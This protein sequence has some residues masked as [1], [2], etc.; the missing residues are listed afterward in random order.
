MQQDLFDLTIDTMCSCSVVVL[1]ASSTP[2][3]AAFFLLKIVSKFRDPALSVTIRLLRSLPHPCSHLNSCTRHLFKNILLPSPPKAP[4]V[5]LVMSLSIV[6]SRAVHTILLP[7]SV[8]PHNLP[9]TLLREE[10]LTSADEV[11][12]SFALPL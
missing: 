10:S 12:L 7:P 8:L 11:T 1:F 3:L 6:Y 9:H 2:R 4:W 5:S